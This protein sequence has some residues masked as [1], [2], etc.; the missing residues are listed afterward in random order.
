MM[1]SHSFRSRVS[2]GES[3]MMSIFNFDHCSGVDLD[4]LIVKS[5]IIKLELHIPRNKAHLYHYSRL[6]GS[7]KVSEKMPTYPSPKPTFCL[8]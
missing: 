8:K 7:I 2:E 6:S 3:I 4:Y 1:S 5:K